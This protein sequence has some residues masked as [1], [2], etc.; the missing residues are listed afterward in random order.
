MP[1]IAKKITTFTKKE[2]DSAF[3]KAR[4]MLKKPGLTILV[5][6]AQK[7]FGRVLIIASKK[8][9]SAPERN[10]LRRRLKSIFYEEKLYEKPFDCIIITNKLAVPLSFTEL[11]SLLLQAY[12]NISAQ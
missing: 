9:G 3:K 10:L 1:R 8:V 4:R 7:E 12:S 11:K 2:V 5:A 6:P